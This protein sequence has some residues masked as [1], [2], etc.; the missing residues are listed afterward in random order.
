MNIDQNLFL[1]ATK[2]VIKNF[3]GGYYHPDM[4]LDGRLNPTAAQIDLMKYSGETMFGLDR[5]AGHSLY[6]TS[7]RISKDVRT[8]LQYI[9][10]YT[11]KN[12][13]SKEFWGILDYQNA[14]QLWKWNYKGG[15]LENKLQTLAAK[16]LYPVFIE[17]SDKYLIS[18]AAKKAV[19]N[20]PKLLFHF[21]YAVWNGPVF[22][23][24]FAK[25][26]QEDLS[27]NSNADTLVKN[28]ISAR[29]NSAVASSAS[30]M[31]KV[32]AS[33]EF[34]ELLKKKRKKILILIG[35]ALLISAAVVSR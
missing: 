4:L 19:Y 8:N 22:F 7:P 34:N 24:K 10:G 15:A 25:K 33:T 31:V 16:I 27:N 26:L 20:N 32:F 2:L 9:P 29:A 23:Q 17:Y 1:D 12:N 13:A 18:E 21:I 6:Y 28:Q 30:K 3:E 35:G 14:A 5:H 11:Y